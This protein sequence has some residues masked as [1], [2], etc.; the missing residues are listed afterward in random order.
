MS[1]NNPLSI[2]SSAGMTPTEEAISRVQI[3]ALINRYASLARGI[4]S[5]QIHRDLASLFLP[6][7]KILLPD[8]RALSPHEI[9]KITESNPPDLLRHHVTTV[10]IQFDSR[11]EARCQT[12]VIAGTHLRMPDHWGRWDDVVVRMPEDGRWLIERKVVVVDGMEEGGWLQGV[13][14]AGVDQRNN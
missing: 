13:V 8:G 6:S 5:P 9:G 3:L 10:D 12:Y 4:P 14:D 7:A 11:T 1:T 2:G